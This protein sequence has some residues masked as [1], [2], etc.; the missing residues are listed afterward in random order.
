MLII[1]KYAYN[2]KL[3]DF[4][5]LIKVIAVVIFLIITT[6]ISN[7]YLNAFIFLGMVFLTTVVAG[8]PF[9]N[10]IKILIIPLSFLLISTITI[11][12]SISAKDVYIYSIKVGSKYIGITDES[13]LMSV[14]TAIRVFASLSLTFFLSLTTSLNKLIIVFNKMKFPKV[15]IELLVLIYRFIFIFLE[16]SINIHRA[17][18]VRFG[19]N[20]F[21][22]SL[23]STSLLIKSLFIRVLLRYKDMVNSLDSKLYNGEFKVGD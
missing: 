7:N 1:D 4:N 16:E 13:I 11:L 12:L 21:R 3:A 6:A 22:N 14:N 10:Y 19:Y 9:K 5:P 8:I 23:N 18:E 20:N 15:I 17:Q 2:N